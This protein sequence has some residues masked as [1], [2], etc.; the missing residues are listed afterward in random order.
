MICY[1]C[2]G[3]DVVTNLERLVCGHLHLST[4]I[5]MF[6]M[7]TSIPSSS[8]FTSALV[9]VRSNLYFG[10]DFCQPLVRTGWWVLCVCVDTST[11]VYCFFVSLLVFSSVFHG[12][13][14]SQDRTCPL[15][16]PQSVQEPVDEPRCHW[17][18]WPWLYS[19]S[20]A[21][22]VSDSGSLG[23]HVSSE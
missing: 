5:T 2:Y 1:I 18:W 16:F 21:P 20:S 11:C 4:V 7:D 6:T 3:V 9:K 15:P 14:Q 13:L 10:K 19:C 12:V 23:P 22:G 17:P 8:V